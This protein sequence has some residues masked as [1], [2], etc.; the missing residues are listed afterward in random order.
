MENWILVGRDEWK[1]REELG[2]KWMTRYRLSKDI[3]GGNICSD[4]STAAG[5]SRAN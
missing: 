1:H 3:C 5:W 2:R 4:F